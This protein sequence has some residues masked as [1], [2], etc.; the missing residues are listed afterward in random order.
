MIWKAARVLTPRVAVG[1]LII[2]HL[3]N[4]SDRETIS[5][6]KENPYMQYFLGLNH[7]QPKAVFDP[8]LFVD[9]RK[10]MQLTNYDKINR[11]LINMSRKEDEEYKGKG[12]KKRLKH[13]GRLQL[14]ATVADQ[15]IKYPTDLDLLN[16]SREWAE[17]IIDEIYPK[18]FL[19]KKPRTYRRVARRD[20]L[21]IA[22]KKNKSRSEEHTSELQSRGHLVCRLLLEKKKNI[23]KIKRYIYQKKNKIR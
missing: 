11:L 12:R 9:L 8:S 21:N 22:K 23:K 5:M 14:D 16:E 19:E 13:W 17:K 3:L 18:T 4:L 6:I 10:R 15:Y 2:K 7:F 1:A 20:Y